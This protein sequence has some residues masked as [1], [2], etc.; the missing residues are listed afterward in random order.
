MTDNLKSKE[1]D[2]REKNQPEHEIDFK[3]SHIH[4]LEDD[5]CIICGKTRKEIMKWRS[6][7]DD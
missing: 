7:L 3:G 2:K 4:H 1:W 6:L 5:K